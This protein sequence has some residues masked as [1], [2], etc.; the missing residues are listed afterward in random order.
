LD[1]KFRDVVIHLSNI[2]IVTDKT[3]VSIEKQDIVQCLLSKDVELK[4]KNIYDYKM[5]TKILSGKTIDD[6]TKKGK[7]LSF[8]F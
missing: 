7:E 6:E 8:T 4:G 5:Y 3:S 2:V 1:G